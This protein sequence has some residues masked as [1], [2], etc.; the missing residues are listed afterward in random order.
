MNDSISVPRG[1]ERTSESQLKGLR[2]G[3]LVW[4]DVLE[5]VGVEVAVA[6]AVA[7]DV[8]EAVEVEVAD[9]VEVAVAV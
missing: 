7:E 1:T 4:V 3:V 2:E 9:L 8:G 5:A 6:V